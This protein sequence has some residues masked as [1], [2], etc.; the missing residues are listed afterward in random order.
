MHRRPC[1]YVHG[2]HTMNPAQ[3]FSHTQQGSEPCGR[4]STL[5]F[6]LIPLFFCVSPPLAATPSCERPKKA[7]IP[8]PRH[9]NIFLW[10]LAFHVFCFISPARARSSSPKRPHN[11]TIAKSNRGTRA[12]TKP[13]RERGIEDQTLYRAAWLLLP[14]PGARWVRRP[15]N[16]PRKTVHISSLTGKYM[17]P[18]PREAAHIDCQVEALKHAVSR[19]G[20]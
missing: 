12:L 4:T 7:P 6:V 18:D 15:A 5:F 17:N 13:S 20:I 19:K 8:F 9:Q 1:R 10:F 11:H 3:S 2:L 16:L 14:R